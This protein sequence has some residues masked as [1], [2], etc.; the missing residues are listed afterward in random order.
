MTVEPKIPQ[1]TVVE[2]ELRL[3]L[4]TAQ[5]ARFNIPR[6]DYSFAADADRI[7][8]CLTPRPC[9]TRARYPERWSPHRFEKLGALYVMP[10]GEPIQIRTDGGAQR[11]ILCDLDAAEVQELLHGKLDWSSHLEAGLDIPSKTVSDLLRR[12]ARELHT[13]G[14]ATEAIAELILAQTV[15]ELARCNHELGSRA[16]ASGLAAWRMRRIDERL[17]EVREPPTL[18][19]LAGHCRLSVRQL[20]RAFRAARGCSIADYLNRSRIETAKRLLA[21]DEPIKSVALSMGFA[22]AS[23]FSRAFRRATG[24]TPSAFRTQSF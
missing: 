11:S 4:G 6:L 14:F 20:T 16:R 1:I 22:S 7:D 19:E 17:A 15:L 5:L 10:K 12:L 13:P 21:R 23:H 24:M 9:N 3:P 8:L 2:A 18:S